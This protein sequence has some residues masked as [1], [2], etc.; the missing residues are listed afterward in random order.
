[1]RWLKK[2]CKEIYNNSD[3]ERVSAE[4]EVPIFLQLLLK[5]LMTLI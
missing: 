3:T 4:F 2:D 1:M 5:W